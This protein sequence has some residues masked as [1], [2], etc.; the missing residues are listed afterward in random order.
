MG[1]Q[2]YHTLPPCI[3]CLVIIGL[4]GIFYQQKL[5][6]DKKNNL[7]VADFEKVDET[8]NLTYDFSMGSCQ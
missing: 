1:P 2:D 8:T 4:F 5:W 3:Y 7:T 6:V